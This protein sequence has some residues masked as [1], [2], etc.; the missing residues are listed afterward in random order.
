MKLILGTFAICTL[1]VAAALY[2]IT[3]ILSQLLPTLIVAAAAGAL[4][5]AIA[6]HRREPTS[7]PHVTARPLPSPSPAS[8][9]WVFLPVWVPPA[10]PP[11]RCYIDAEV[12]E[13]GRSG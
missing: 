3:V 10:P 13:D 11:T 6:S 2:A 1:G 12:I 7:S 8:G 9:H 5:H 4:W